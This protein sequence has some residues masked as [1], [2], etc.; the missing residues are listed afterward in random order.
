MGGY[1][2][3][4]DPVI[5]RA[6]TKKVASYPIGTCVKLSS[7]ETGI[8]IKNYESTSLRPV[9]KLVVDD[10][11]VSKTIDLTNDRSSLNITVKEILDL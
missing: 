7:G 2:S 8:V 1:G 11:P 4:F 5:V 10:K 3:M 6:I 9:V